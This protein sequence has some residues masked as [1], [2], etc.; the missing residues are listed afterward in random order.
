VET[1]KKVVHAAQKCKVISAG[2]SKQ[3]D[4]EFLSKAREV[5]RAGA[6]G[7]AI[8]RNVWQ[9][10]NPVKMAEAVRKVIWGKE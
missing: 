3:T 7:F 10:E 1:F 2:G 5:M 6:A 4:E 8:G 9:N